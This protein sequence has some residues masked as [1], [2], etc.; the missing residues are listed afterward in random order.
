[1]A[2]TSSPG[3]EVLDDTASVLPLMSGFNVK[4]LRERRKQSDWYAY[5]LQEEGLE[6]GQKGPASSASHSVDVC[7]K[8]LCTQKPP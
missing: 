1:M 3:A 8:M 5:K 7:R 6:H 4:K 2:Q